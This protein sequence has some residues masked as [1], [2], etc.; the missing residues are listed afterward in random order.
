MPE[1]ICVAY[2]TIEV[3]PFPD[4]RGKRNPF[5]IKKASPLS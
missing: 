2:G 5:D 1:F 4:R 3:V